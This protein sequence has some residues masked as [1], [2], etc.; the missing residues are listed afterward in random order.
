MKIVKPI[1]I[2]GTGRCGSSIFHKLLSRHPNIAWLS[3]LNNRLPGVPGLHKGLLLADSV[4]PFNRFIKRILPPSETTLYWEYLAPGFSTAC[5]NLTAD[6]LHRDVKTRTI[7]KLERFVTPQ[8]NRQ[9]HKFTGWPRIGYLLDLFPDAC[10]IHIFRDGRAVALSY[11]QQPWWTGWR[12]PDNWLW[13][14]LPGKYNQEWQESGRSFTVLAA[15]NWKLLMD[16]IDRDTANLPPGRLLQIKY[17][18]LTADP[19]GIFNSVLNFCGLPKSAYFD[20]FIKKQ[21]LTC[22]NDGWKTAL[23]K[24][25]QAV[26][27]GSLREHLARYGYGE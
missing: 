22:R 15:I 1:L 27:N 16:A 7:R 14:T 19:Q 13:G 3:G 2:I 26:L 10:F 4:F 12:G 5:R 17:E 21:N 20:R 11:L 18:S 8:R 23:S 6:D 9:M 24:K 25:Q